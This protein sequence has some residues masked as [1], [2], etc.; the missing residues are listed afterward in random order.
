M[1][2]ERRGFKFEELQSNRLIRVKEEVTISM[3]ESEN[4]RAGALLVSENN[5]RDDQT[6]QSKVSAVN[7]GWTI[8][9]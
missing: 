5:V 8:R 1:N 2:E 3:N 9:R 6:E 7:D 4:D